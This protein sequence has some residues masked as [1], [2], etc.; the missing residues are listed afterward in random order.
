MST[1][2]SWHAIAVGN[3]LLGP[4]NFI[5]LT[6]PVGWRL[7]VMP[8]ASEVFKHR[9]IN[10]VKWVRD[11]EVMHFLRDGAEVYRLVVRIKPGR[12]KFDGEPIVVNNHEGSY[13]IRDRGGRY[14]LEVGYY[15]PET[16]RTIKISIEGLREL[17]ILRH[18]GYSQCH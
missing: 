11:G 2:Y 17:S 9:E 8:M 16:D 7:V 14:A 5:V 4:Y 15:C 3:R 10:G 13:R 18:L 6:T 12:R 1:E